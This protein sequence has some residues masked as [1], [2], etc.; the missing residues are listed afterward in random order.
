MVA[1]RVGHMVVACFHS[2]V[3]HLQMLVGMVVD[4]IELVHK[5]CCVVNGGLP[6]VRG[7]PTQQAEFSPKHWLPEVK[8]VVSWVD[9]LWQGG[10]WA[11]L[12]PI[13]LA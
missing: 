2:V 7:S 1:R 9:A 12:R 11:V 13:S 5:V 8:P 6:L 10:R 3:G 4:V